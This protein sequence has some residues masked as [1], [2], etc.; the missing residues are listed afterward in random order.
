MKFISCL[1]LTVSML[2]PPIALAADDEKAKGN[3]DQMMDTSGQALQLT[4]E[5]K[6]EDANK[7]LKHFE[8]EMEQ[9][10]QKEQLAL[11]MKDLRILTTV[12]HQATTM[13]TNVSAGHEKRMTAVTRFYLVVDA[14]QSEN[15]PLWRNTKNQVMTPFAKM[16]Q[17]AADKNKRDFQ[18]YAN[19]FLN[20]YEMIHPALNVDLK[21]PVIERLESEVQ[22][23]INHR[24]HF[25]NDSKY[26]KF[27]DRMEQDFRALFDGSLEESMEPALPWVILSIGGIIAVTLF[28]AG[29]QKYRAE[30]Q[31]KQRKV[32]KR[33]KF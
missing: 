24:D 22:F 28:Y 5:K 31:S 15:Q 26:V 16:R 25:F 10:R 11:T 19:Q 23:L 1:L 6:Y 14:L 2:V 4:R 9:S 13:L 12:H 30:K 33:S 20:K 8:K 32:K 27:L 17:A 18:L 29:W 7:L 3:W 21:A